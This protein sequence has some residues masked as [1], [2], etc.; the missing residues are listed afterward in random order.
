MAPVVGMASL[1][2]SVV[3]SKVAVAAPLPSAAVIRS[4]SSPTALGVFV[5]F[6]PVAFFLRRP[7]SART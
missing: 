4:R 3:S 5:D 7:T 2:T 6:G 1:G